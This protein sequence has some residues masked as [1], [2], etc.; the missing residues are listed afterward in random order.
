MGD[1]GSLGFF[2]H[3]AQGKVEQRGDTGIHDPVEDMVADAAG[4]NHACVGQLLELVGNSLRFHA[5]DAGDIGDGS[6]AGTNQVMQQ[7][8]AGIAGKHFEQ[9]HNL[10]GIE[11]VE[12][13]FVFERRRC[14]AAIYRTVTSLDRFSR[15]IHFHSTITSYCVLVAQQVFSYFPP[16]WHVLDLS[17]ICRRQQW[18]HTFETI[19]L[20][21]RGLLLNPMEEYESDA[22]FTGELGGSGGA[23]FGEAEGEFIVEQ[24]IDS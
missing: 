4:G 11:K 15:H 3:Q 12:Q 9:C 2:G 23:G 13:G 18:L 24:S 22:G 5:K 14:H 6:F 16:L 19:D 1:R 21:D 17:R 20:Q 7:P 8:D 10:D